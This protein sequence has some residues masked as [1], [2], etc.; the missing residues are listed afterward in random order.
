LSARARRVYGTHGRARN[1]IWTAVMKMEIRA[2]PS[3]LPSQPTVRDFE[4]K[5]PRRN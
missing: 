4:R 1:L 3:K 5:V 2:R